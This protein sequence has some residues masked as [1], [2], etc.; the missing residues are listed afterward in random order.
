MPVTLE[1]KSD[2]PAVKQNR[3][4]TARRTIDYFGDRIS[5]AASLSLSVAG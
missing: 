2:N 5:F 1:D 4:A 3:K